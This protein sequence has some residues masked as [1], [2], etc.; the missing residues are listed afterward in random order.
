MVDTVGTVEQPNGYCNTKR[1]SALAE[2]WSGDGSAKLSAMTFLVV[3]GV[4]LGVW[5]LAAST[6]VLLAGRLPPGLV[7]D[8]AE[9]LPACVTTA[10]A[11]RRDRAVPRRAKVAMLVA[12]VWMLSPIDLLPEFLPVIG[13]LDDVIAVVLLLRYAARSVPRSRLEAAWPANPATLR[14]LLAR[15]PRRRKG[16][17]ATVDD[18]KVEVLFFDG[19]PNH[20]ALLP[21]LRD[22]LE[23]ANSGADV[24]LVR[25]EDAD[26]AMR[27]RF[28]GS[29]T[30]RIDGE[31]VEP[32]AD[33]RTD[34][35]LKCR[36]FR[37]P[38]GVRGMP[39]DE[40]ILDA[41]QRATARC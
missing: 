41:L 27:E 33:D 34:F 6:L 21:H 36:L 19:C 24:E 10:R 23:G 11:L 37:T 20:A 15:L 16:C 14:R 31:D 3:G 9:F 13:L 8:I 7:R 32:G 40:W 29:P 2:H 28:L 25:V 30:V 38:D 26:A 12:I 1:L 5:G 35:G 4:A 22:V 39:A 17:A 18:V